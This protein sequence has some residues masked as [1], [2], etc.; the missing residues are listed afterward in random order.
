MYNMF[1]ICDTVVKAILMWFKKKKI[2]FTICNGFKEIHKVS[3]F[4]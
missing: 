3:I 2:D 1:N 4:V